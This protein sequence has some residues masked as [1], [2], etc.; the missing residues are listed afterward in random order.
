MRRVSLIIVLA[1]NEA[2]TAQH[3]FVS[4]GI[5]SVVAEIDTVYGERDQ[6]TLQGGLRYTLNRW[7]SRRHNLFVQGLVGAYLA[8]DL[9]S[10]G[11]S[12][13]VGMDFV[14]SETGHGWGVRLQY[15]P[16]WVKD[17][18]DTWYQQATVA[19]IYRFEK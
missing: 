13:G 17:R 11:G 14:F 1:L 8:D 19:V 2:R 3:L 9:T 5:V 12:V 6:M 7:P 16:G 18:S 4:R 15:D 10:L